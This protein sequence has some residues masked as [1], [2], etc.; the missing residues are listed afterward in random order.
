MTAAIIRIRNPAIRVPIWSLWFPVLLAELT[1]RFLFTSRGLGRLT[2]A[3]YWH[4]AGA[5]YL[6]GLDGWED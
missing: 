6:I 4:T 1:V 5:I 3:G 2:T